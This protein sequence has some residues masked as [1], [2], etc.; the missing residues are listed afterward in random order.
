MSENGK[1]RMKYYVV[2]VGKKPG[3]YRT[4]ED[5]QK[6]TEGFKNAEHKSFNVEKDAKMY[7]EEGIK[8]RKGNSV[9]EEGNKKSK[10]NNAANANNSTVE[11]VAENCENNVGSKEE[12]SISQLSGTEETEE[13]QRE[14]EVYTLSPPVIRTRLITENDNKNNEEHN[15]RGENTCGKCNKEVGKY[16]KAVQCDQCASLV[17]ST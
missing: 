11:G 4:W 12:E 3:I 9:K 1:K 10:E 17:S 2:K 16:A 13:E 5:C 15:Q 6:N 7:L 14:D 8:Y